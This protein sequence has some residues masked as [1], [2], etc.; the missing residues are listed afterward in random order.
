VDYDELSIYQEVASGNFAFFIESPYRSVQ[1]DIG[2][3]HA[4]F[5]D[6]N[7]GT[8]SLLIDCELLNVAF[9]FRTF[10]PVGFAR[11]GIGTGHT[12]LEPSLLASLKITQDTYLQTQVAYWIPIGGDQDYKGATWHY[13][14]SL[15]HCWWQKGAL[16]FIGT[17]EFN[18]WSFTDGA[19]TDIVAGNA[20]Q[21][22]ASGES[23]FTAGGGL[24]VVGVVGGRVVDGSGIVITVVEPRRWV[25]LV[26]PGRVVV[27]RGWRVVVVHPSSLRSSSPDR[28]AVVAVVDALATVTG[29]AQLSSPLPSVFELTLS[30]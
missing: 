6:I 27:V 10:I 1:P 2:D 28:R 13:H 22:K 26:V 21:T 17:A 14:F 11:N 15:N 12:S 19:V 18:G 24:R 16:Q 30:G 29:R 8:K 4:N 25:V 9:Q 20:V 7:L 3:H 5:G 23:Y